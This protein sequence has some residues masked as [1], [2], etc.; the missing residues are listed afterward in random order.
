MKKLI[1]IIFL[2]SIVACITLSSLAQ[3]YVYQLTTSIDGWFQQG[4]SDPALNWQGVGQIFDFGSLSETVYYNPTA[5]TIRQVGSFTLAT[6]TFS[7]SFQDNKVVQGVGLVAGVLSVNYTLND[8]NSAVYFDSWTQPVGANA[9]MN[10]SIPFS[11]TYSL[12]TGGLVYNGSVSGVIPEANT[13]TSISQFTPGSIVISQ[14]NS[15]AREI[16][17]LATWSAN[18]ADGW[19]GVIYD[20]IGDN[21]SS[22]NY[23][24]PPVIAYA[25]PE[26]C[27]G[28][29]ARIAV[30]IPVLFLRRRS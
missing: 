20:S 7:G 23:Y 27:W 29:S 3:D 6:T 30:V 2:C 17:S 22:E 5:D 26:P 24:V 18:A 15:V 11:E 16:G 4:A 12:M 8:G 28:W 21:S 19:S 10:W 1:S 25:V 13:Q 14:G 9:A